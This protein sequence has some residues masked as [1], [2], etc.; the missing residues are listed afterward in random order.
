MSRPAVF[1]PQARRDLLDA[2]QWIARDNRRAT[3][4]LRDGIVAAAKRIGKM[5]EAG[6]ERLDLADPPIRFLVLTGFPYI[7]V[8]DAARRPPLVLRVLHGAR[9]L[10][11]LLRDL[12]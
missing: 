9:D 5:P 2:A 8:Y 1:A 4:A 11:D 12:G 10:P 7:L 6:V 3:L